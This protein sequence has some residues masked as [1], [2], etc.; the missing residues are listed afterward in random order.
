MCGYKAAALFYTTRIVADVA[1]LFVSVCVCVCVLCSPFCR[2]SNSV[3]ETYINAC[4]VHMCFDSREVFHLF[5][6]VSILEARVCPV[7]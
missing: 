7:I 3:H 4:C 5:L 2:T 1:M 6:S